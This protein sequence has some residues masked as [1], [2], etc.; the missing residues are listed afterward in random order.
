MQ[1]K[2]KQDVFYVG[3]KDPIEIRRSLLESSKEIVQ[4]MQDFERFKDM[5]EQKYEL[6]EQLRKD[7]IAIEAMMKRLRKFIPK[8]KLRVRL[9]Q[10]H[11]ELDEAEEE[12]PATSRRKSSKKKSSKALKSSKSK[13]AK[14]VKEQP[15]PKRALTELDKLEE[16]L[17][18]IEEKLG[19]L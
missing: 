10:E 5:R 11:K 18:K 1:S 6:K 4:L 8:T 19:T 7:I 12:P 2:D 14:K 15:K 3:I 16:E 17:R 9:A 13:K